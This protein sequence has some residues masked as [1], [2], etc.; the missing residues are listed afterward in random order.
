MAA[1]VTVGGAHV[2]LMTREKWQRSWVDYGELTEEL[3][4]AD[5]VWARKVVT[6]LRQRQLIP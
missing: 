6:L 3:K 1:L 4:E 2:P 5:R